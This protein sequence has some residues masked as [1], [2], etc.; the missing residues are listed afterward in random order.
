V[1]YALFDLVYGGTAARN[2]QMFE[3]ASTGTSGAVGRQVTL[4]AA[5]VASGEANAMLVELELA[6][7]RGVV[8]LRGAGRLN[9][10]PVTLSYLQATNNYQ[11]GDVVKTRAQLLA[12][13]TSGALLATLTGH[14]RA[15]TTESTAQPLLS[16]PGGSGAGNA[17][18]PCGTGSPGGVLPNTTTG[19]PRLP[20]I[21][22]ANLVMLL[23]SRNVAAVDSV[24]VDGAPATGA[25]I[26]VV[27]STPVCGAGAITP[28]EIQVTL[29]SKPT[30]NGTHLL[31]IRK[32]GLLSNELPFVVQ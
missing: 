25:S 24:F 3:E 18:A 17:G 15:G 1:A 12:D 27:G 5:T 8:N 9:A 16:V 32:G 7:T 14:L 26:S 10:A 21:S 29:G 20:I 13:A 23:E 4:N 30:P 6:D 22:N 31:Q 19:D 11:V 2:F 28:D